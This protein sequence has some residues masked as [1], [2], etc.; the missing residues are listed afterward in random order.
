VVDVGLDACAITYYPAVARS[1]SGTKLRLMLA[2]RGSR[3]RLD[4]LTTMAKARPPWSFIVHEVD[5]AAAVHEVS[6]QRL[7]ASLDARRR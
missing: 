6:V 5:D 2:D 1:S 4:C 3:V 7:M